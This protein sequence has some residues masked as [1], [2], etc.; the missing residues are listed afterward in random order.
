MDELIFHDMKVYWLE[1]GVV[2]FDGG[3]IFG[4]VPKPLWSKRYPANTLN[5]IEHATDPML[6]Q[7]CNKNHLMDTGIGNGEF[8]DKQKRNFGVREESKVKENLAEL[9]L[10]EEEIVFSNN[11]VEPP[12]L[13]DTIP[14]NKNLKGNYLYRMLPSSGPLEI[15]QDKL[16]QVSIFLSGADLKYYREGFIDFLPNHFSDIPALLLKR[17]SNPVIM[18]TV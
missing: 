8:S 2:S 1:G 12:M 13:L 18:A 10:T 9:E 14:Q 16:K 17:A 6:V 11:P 5:Q 7:Y 3:A 4:V 15:S